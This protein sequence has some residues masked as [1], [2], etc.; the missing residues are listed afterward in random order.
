MTYGRQGGTYLSRSEHQEFKV[1][2]WYTSRSVWDP[3][4]LVLKTVL[5]AAGRKHWGYF[6]SN[7]L[8]VN[9]GRMTILSREPV[10]I[11]LGVDLFLR[12]T[13]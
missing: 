9:K 2:L 3:S 6:Q 13:S 4:D 8:S 5:P 12:M 7:A 1:S 10:R 11:C